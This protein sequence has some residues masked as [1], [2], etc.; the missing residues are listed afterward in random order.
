MRGT[1]WIDQDQLTVEDGRLRGQLTEGLDH[2]RQ[3]FRVFSAMA[4]VE[5]DLAA[6]LGDLKPKAIPFGF[7]TSIVALEWADGCG[8]RQ[9][10][11]ERETDGHGGKLT[12]GRGGGMLTNPNEAWLPTGLPGSVF[13]TIFRGMSVCIKT[14]NTDCPICR[15]T[16]RVESRLPFRKKTCDECA[17]TSKVPALRREVLLM[18]MK[19]RQ[20]A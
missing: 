3:P 20:R 6:I 10:A 9:G 16:G 19:E 1:T 8:W 7:V 13:V 18:R 2:A 12:G 5:P 14:I 17:G 11:D 15:G 4:R